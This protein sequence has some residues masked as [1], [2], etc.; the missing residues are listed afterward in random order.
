MRKIIFISMMSLI[1]SLAM[2]VSEVKAQFVYSYADVA[3][4]EEGLA[5]GEIKA[6]GPN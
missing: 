3:A 5:F 4:F 2:T 6:L 1:W